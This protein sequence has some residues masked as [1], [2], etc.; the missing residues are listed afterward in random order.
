V[1]IFYSGDNSGA[2]KVMAELGESIVMQRYHL[3]HVAMGK[4]YGRMNQ[5]AKANEHFTKAIGL[6]RQDVEKNF[7]RNLMS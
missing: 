7:I 4:F 5:L 1:A 6:T 2:M 3:Y